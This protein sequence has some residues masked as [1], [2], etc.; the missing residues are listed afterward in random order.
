M[1]KHNLSVDPSNKFSEPRKKQ[2]QTGG[3]DFDVSFEDDNVDK[4]DKEIDFFPMTDKAMDAVIQGK[5]SWETDGILKGIKMRHHQAFMEKAFPPEQEKTFA[6]AQV[7]SACMKTFRP[8]SE[9]DYIIY[10]I[11]HCQKGTEVKSLPPGPERDRLISFHCSNR[12]GNKYIHQ[13]FT[14]EVF[15]PG[16][17]APHT[18]LRKYNK[19]GTPAVSY[20]H[21][22]L[23]TKA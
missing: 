15:A 8:Q 11:T 21:L 1:E 14:E 6:N 20:T 9:I 10:V 19:D 12:S 16:D 2:K 23:P 13:Y 4:D 17:T 22:T 5:G 18:V 7:K 3:E